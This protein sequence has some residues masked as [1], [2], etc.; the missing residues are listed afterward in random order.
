MCIPTRFHP[1]VEID[2]P[3]CRYGMFASS[4]VVLRSKPWRMCGVEPTKKLGY[5]L[6]QSM[7]SEVVPNIFHVCAS[8]QLMQYLSRE[9][10]RERESKCMCA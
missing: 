8:A 1:T 7:K 3:N 4:A 10:V 5:L 6:K 2:G 9:R